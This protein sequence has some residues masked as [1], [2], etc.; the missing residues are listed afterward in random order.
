MAL[1]VQ[2][3]YASSMMNAALPEGKGTTSASDEKYKREKSAVQKT[4]LPMKM[5]V[6]DL[7]IVGAAF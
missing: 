5:L 3:E 2:F 6:N 4:A 1:I 7:V